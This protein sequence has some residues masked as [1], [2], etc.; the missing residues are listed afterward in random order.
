MFR[1]RVYRKTRIQQRFV[2]ASIH[3][4][5]FKRALFSGAYN[6]FSNPPTWLWESVHTCLALLL[7]PCM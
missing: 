3:S 5:R 2:R 7:I 1:H 6:I 4:G